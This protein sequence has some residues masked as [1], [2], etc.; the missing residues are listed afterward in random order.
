M[1]ELSLKNSHGLFYFVIDQ[2]Y[3]GLEYKLIYSQYFNKMM[4]A[5]SCIYGDIHWKPFFL[6]SLG[7]II[8]ALL[9]SISGNSRFFFFAS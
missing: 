1:T 3:C 7:S 4:R 6:Q 2:V 8:F 9:L 5:Y